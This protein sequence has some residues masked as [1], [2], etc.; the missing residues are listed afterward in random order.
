MS[1]TRRPVIVCGYDG[2]P[3]G[4][5]AL[6]AAVERVGDGQ[7]VVVHASVIPVGYGG[8]S[9]GSLVD[10]IRAASQRT[11]DEL[12]GVEPGLAD[13]SWEARQPVGPAAR[14]LNAVAQE[15]DADM[16][17]IGSRGVGSVHALLGSV[18][19]ET[20]HLAA[21]PVLVVPEAA[22]GDAPTQR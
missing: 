11:V 3:T 6:Q 2:S 13:V 12:P 17:V 8:V 1:D 9:Y 10:D 20:I 22:L 19:Y 4:K 15:V 5:A 14:E 21:C 16:I 18:A 7:L